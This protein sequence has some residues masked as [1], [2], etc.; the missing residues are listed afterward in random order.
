MPNV[1]DA[2]TD[3]KP[4]A[5]VI[6]PGANPDVKPNAKSN[7]ND[8][9]KTSPGGGGGEKLGVFAVRGYPGGGT[10]TAHAIW[11][12][13]EADREEDESP[14]EIHCFRIFGVYPLDD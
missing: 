7:P 11:C 10:E 14:A 2:K 4:I 1:I 13:N 8:N 6:K 9:L 12:R 3:V 5:P